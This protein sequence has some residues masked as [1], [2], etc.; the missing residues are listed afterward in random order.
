MD[1]VRS[2]EGELPLFKSPRLKIVELS[3]LIT[4]L[5]PGEFLATEA[6]K[7]KGAMLLKPR[8]NGACYWEKC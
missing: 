6:L 2:A 5:L 7:K 3:F 4:S 8:N 1:D